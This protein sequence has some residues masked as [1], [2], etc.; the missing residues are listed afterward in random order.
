MKHMHNVGCW[1]PEKKKRVQPLAIVCPLCLSNSKVAHMIRVKWSLELKKQVGTCGHC[2]DVSLSSRLA[3]SPSE[4]FFQVK[5]VLFALS[6]NK[7]T[8][9]TLWKI[10]WRDIVSEPGWLVWGYFCTTGEKRNVIVVDMI[11]S[12]IFVLYS[13]NINEQDM[14]YNR[15]RRVMNNSTIWG[16]GFENNVDNLQLEGNTTGVKQ[17]WDTKLGAQL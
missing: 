10:Y 14:V 5:S 12:H 17:I 4:H 16:L 7:I 9:A 15:K 11:S 2:K 1:D 13:R 8:L 6:F 3:F